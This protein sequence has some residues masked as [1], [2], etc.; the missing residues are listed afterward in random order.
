MSLSGR[1][2]GQV[3]DDMVTSNIESVPIITPICHSRRKKD[4]WIQMIIVVYRP[5]HIDDGPNMLEEI[6]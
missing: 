6:S 3:K 1:R 5:N 4:D 2:Q